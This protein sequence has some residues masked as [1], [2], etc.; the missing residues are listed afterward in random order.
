LKRFDKSTFLSL[1][2][3]IVFFILVWIFVLGILLGLGYLP[4]RSR[5]FAW[6]P[7]QSYTHSLMG[8]VMGRVRAEIA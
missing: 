8:D 7:S 2:L 4:G 1:V 5:I 6:S 3:V